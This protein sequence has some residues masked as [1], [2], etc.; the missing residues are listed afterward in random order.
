MGRNGGSE[1]ASSF[2]ISQ[3]WSYFALALL[4]LYAFA[5]SIVAAAGKPF[6]YDELLTTVVA[7]Q[8]SWRFSDRRMGSPHCFM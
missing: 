5:R 1:K 2:E 7:A 3:K 4:L 8:G 6:W